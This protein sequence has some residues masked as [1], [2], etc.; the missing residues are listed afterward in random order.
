MGGYPAI[1]N[2]QPEKVWQ[3]RLPL[4]AQFL[5]FLGYLY[6]LAVQVPP[7]IFD[8]LRSLFHLK[9]FALLATHRLVLMLTGQLSSYKAQRRLFSLTG[10]PM[11]AQGR[12]IGR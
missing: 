7:C 5:I 1:T 3:D 2:R 11:G 4:T 8:F 6:V 9:L 10:T 12:N